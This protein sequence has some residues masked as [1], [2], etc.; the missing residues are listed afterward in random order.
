M[1]LSEGTI[2]LLF[3]LYYARTHGLAPLVL[4]HLY[5]DVGSTL[6]YWIRL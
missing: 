2:F 1:A 6:M 3:S 4:A 5:M